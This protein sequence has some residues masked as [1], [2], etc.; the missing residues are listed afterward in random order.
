MMG[1]GHAYKGNR[2][3]PSQLIMMIL[4]RGRPMY[5]YELIKVLREEYDGVWEPQTGS[6]YP[7]LRRLQDHGLLSVENTEGRD[8]YSISAEG[9]A[10]L[11]ETLSSISSGVMF[12]V[13]TMGIIGKASMQDRARTDSFVPLDE[14]P[15]EK[16]LLI[17]KGI[18]E[19]MLNNL[20]MMDEHIEEVESEIRK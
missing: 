17:L 1:K 7:A 14:E 8:H 5:G 15:P 11:N 6:I 16:R 2:I 19:T 18:R 9:N 13:R 4:L 12:M 10:W 20:K 3:S